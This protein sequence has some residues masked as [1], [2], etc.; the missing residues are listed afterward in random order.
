MMTDWRG[1]QNRVTEAIQNAQPDRD[2]LRS[3]TISVIYVTLFL[4][5]ERVT[6]SFEFYPNLTSWYLPA[7]LTFTLF[8]VYGRSYTPVVILAHLISDVWLRPL[9]T[10]FPRLILLAI[11]V[12]LV[13]LAGASAVK[14]AMGGK[15]LSVACSTTFGP[16]LLGSIATAVGV[17]FV[18]IVNLLAAQLIELK[19]ITDAFLVGSMGTAVGILAVSPILILQVIPSIEASLKDLGRAKESILKHTSHFPSRE[20]IAPIIFQLFVVASV[21]WVVFAIP[22]TDQ[23]WRLSCLSLPLVWVA[24]ASGLDGVSRFIFGLVCGAIV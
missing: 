18:T 20:R 8:L 13:Y 11:S 2:I 14:K 21:L 15:R 12:S 3:F 24:L 6:S 5:G 1:I 4:L 7:G 9:D 17:T 22:A 10:S 23:A 19:N 16:L